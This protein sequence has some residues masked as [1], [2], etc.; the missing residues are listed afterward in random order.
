RGRPAAHMRGLGIEAACDGA[1]VAVAADRRPVRASLI[2]GQIDVHRRFGGVVPELAS[3]AHV[4]A[5]NP[6]LDEALR[7]AGVT[8]RDL[9]GVAVTVGPGLIGALLVGV[10]AAKAVSPAT[11]APLIGVN[12][13]EG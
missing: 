13:L 4:E 7:E 5:L 8:A 3:R 2:S 1:A 9:D 10:A 12:H 6:M 11:G